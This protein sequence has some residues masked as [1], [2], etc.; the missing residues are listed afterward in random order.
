M[1]DR[2]IALKQILIIKSI[3][4]YAAAYSLVNFVYFSSPDGS[5]WLLA[6][7]KWIFAVLLGCEKSYYIFFSYYNYN[8]CFLQ[9][10]SAGIILINAYS[11]K[12][13]LLR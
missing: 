3:L 4:S 6:Q 2:I 7:F 13:E 10:L 1:N 5:T 8:S 12:I 9:I 11:W